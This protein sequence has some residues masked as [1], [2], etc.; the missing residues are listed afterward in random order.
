MV[1]STSLDSPASADEY[2]RN[3]ETSRKVIAH[4]S[5]SSLC[6]TPTRLPAD[7]EG[8]A[9]SIAQTPAINATWIS[10]DDAHGMLTTLKW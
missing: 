3:L 6:R 8:S 10:V 7:E 9:W 1:S 5:A 4:S 2:F